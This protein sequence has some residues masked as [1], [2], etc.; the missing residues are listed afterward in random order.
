MP[1]PNY[2]KFQR[3]SIASYERLTK[4]DDN[5][6]YFVYT[7]DDQTTGKL[8]LGSRLISNNVGG[9]NVT[10]LADLSDVILSEVGASNFLVS[11]SEGKWVPVAASEVA[12]L[13]LESNGNFVTIDENEFSFNSVN[14]QLEL[15]GY[16]SASNGMMPVKGNSGL[17][18][19]QAPTDLSSTVE[20]LSN[21]I[22]T[23]E[24]DLAAVDGKISTAISNAAHLKYQVIN[25]L[26]EATDNNIIYLVPNSSSV[27]NNSYDEYMF[28]NNQ[29]EK[30]GTYG[31]DLSEYAKTSELTSL[32]SRVSSLENSLN[33]IDDTYVTKVQF[34]AVV[35]TMSNLSQY[36][37]LNYDTA[38]LSD[39]FEDLYE[40][41]IWQD[42]SE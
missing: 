24:T 9:T 15:K 5:T 6:L 11:N 18:W 39:T 32:N 10:S 21:K 4:K 41:L 1:N 33:N 27:E 12:Q 34:N 35:G 31:I 16:N 23:I 19:V 26:T 13:I 14:G 8:Y 3:G 2:V 37:N 17:E 42:I 38:T 29:L 40:R 7:D 22:T 36:N 25:D 20:N 30:I 28:I